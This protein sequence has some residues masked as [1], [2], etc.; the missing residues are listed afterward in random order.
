MDTI[1]DLL[2]LAILLICGWTGYK[3]GIIMGI[4]GLLALIISIYGANLLSNTFSYEVIDGLRPFASGYVETVS[5]STVTAEF[6][7][8]D[9]K[10]SIRDY[11]KQNPDKELDYCES[12]FRATGIYGKT[13]KGLAEEAMAY[14]EEQNVELTEAVT[15]ILCLRIAYAAGFILAFLLIIIILTVIGN[16]PNLSFKLPNLDMVNDIGGA[17]LGVLTGFSFC[18]VIVW[19][20]QFTGILI[21]QEIIGDTLLASSLMKMG[22]LNKFLGL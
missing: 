19:A 5:D 10:T 16:L 6:G 11:L 14:A 21:S 8:T 4:G 13:A 7:L 3:K 12:C 1:I 18:I 17:V 9:S 22:I 15:E 2:L 20:L